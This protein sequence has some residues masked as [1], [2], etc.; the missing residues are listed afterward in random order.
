M[1][2]FQLCLLCSLLPIAVKDP[3]QL[4]LLLQLCCV[5][6]ALGLSRL[7]ALIN[8]CMKRKHGNNYIALH[9]LKTRVME[10]EKGVN[11]ATIAC[12]LD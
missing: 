12:Y 7:L 1:I 4:L 10:H 9:I 11:C 2:T 5:R 8:H 6:S 3:L